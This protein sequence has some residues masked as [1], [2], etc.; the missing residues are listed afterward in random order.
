MSGYRYS[1]NN[2]LPL[3]DKRD[4]YNRPTREGIDT[5]VKIIAVIGTALWTSRSLSGNPGNNGLPQAE[6]SDNG[7]VGVKNEL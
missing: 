2:L 1:S 5:V 4:G 3:T 7:G 6:S